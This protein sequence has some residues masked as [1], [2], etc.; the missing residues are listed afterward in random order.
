MRVVGVPY[1]GTKYDFER[2]SQI[3]KGTEDHLVV[4]C[5]LLASPTGGNMFEGEDIIKY[6]DLVG[7]DA[8]IYAF[9]HWHKD[10]GI[11]EIAPGQWVV[12]VGSLTRGSLH[13]DDLD[14]EPKAVVMWFGKTAVHFEQVPLKIKPAK[15]VFDLEAREK[16]VK[17]TAQMSQFVDSIQQTLTITNSQPL[18]DLIRALDCDD[19]IKER[20]LAYLEGQQ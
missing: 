16:S 8:S 12:N 10:Q 15:D 19:G 7:L 17:R 14:R 20:C 11:T 5:H 6:Q 4:M 3:K 2:I 1:H 9:G 13:L 18:P